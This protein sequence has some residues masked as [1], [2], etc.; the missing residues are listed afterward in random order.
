MAQRVIFS[1]VFAAI[2]QMTDPRFRRVLLTG[3][4]LALV[5]L[6]GFSVFFVWLIGGFVGDQTTL[7]FVGQVT[8]LDNVVSWGAALLLLVL[9]AFLMVPVASAIASMFLETVA[10][11]VEQEHYPKLAPATPI[12]FADSISDT[13]GFLGVLVLA[14]ILALLLYLLFV[15]LAVFIFWGLNGFL[16]G[17]EYFTL[18]AMRRV[19]R[20]QAKVLRKRHGMTIWLTG[21]LMAIP[22]TVPIMNLIVPILGAAAFTHL[23]HRL[24]PQ[25]PYG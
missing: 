13:L 9:S 22:L 15:P 25:G 24:E 1:C 10:E 2:G 8:W 14:N 21:V 11:A 20:K 16:L 5:L 3:I 19:G 6:I 4:G 12:T 17:R 18:A 7:P 23:F